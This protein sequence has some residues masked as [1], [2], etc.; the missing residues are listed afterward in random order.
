[1]RISETER[2]TPKTPRLTEYTSNSILNQ[3][4]YA[5]NSEE[6]KINDNNEINYEYDI[7]TYKK[8]FCHYNCGTTNCKD[9][10]I[11]FAV[12][13]IIW[14]IIPGI[15]LVF[16]VDSEYEINYL[17]AFI[18]LLVVVFIILYV[19]TFRY[20]GDPL[21]ECFYCLLYEK[22][23]CHLM[24][25][26]KKK[27]RDQY[28]TKEYINEEYTKHKDIKLK[29]EVNE[30]KMKDLDSPYI[31]HLF[32]DSKSNSIRSSN[33]YRQIKNNNLLIID[34]SNA[35]INYFNENN[36]RNILDIIYKFKF[37]LVIH[38][39]IKNEFQ[40][41]IQSTHNALLRNIN[42][43]DF[44]EID[45]KIIDET[46]SICVYKF[47]LPKRNE[48]PIGFY[49]KGYYSLNIN[50]KL[51]QFTNIINICLQ[52]K[53]FNIFIGIILFILMGPTSLI[54]WRLQ[55]K[56]YCME[57]IYSL[58]CCNNKYDI[59]CYPQITKLL[60]T[61]K[62]YVWIKLC[63]NFMIQDFKHELFDQK[64][65]H[66]ISTDIMQIIYLYL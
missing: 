38:E 8:C 32:F 48:E 34:Q 28:Y 1:M 23:Q 14:F 47:S 10:C 60:I 58:I 46:Q 61:K 26:V 22:Y 41:L 57:N 29:I 42:S 56:W 30:R 18:V 49:S 63:I 9:I 21:S 50:K 39:S 15:V 20:Y 7:L 52:S 53:T 62:S 12:F 54:C 59:K 16:Y 31:E 25:C 2:L 24:E 45:L 36:K 35:T 27:Y 5:M 4:M 40:T 3:S 43:H 51:S 64:S 19:F 17:I 44:Y 11:K 37:R 13:F 65:Y 6:L 66:K 33:K 55:I